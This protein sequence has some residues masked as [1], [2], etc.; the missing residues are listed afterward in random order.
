MAG[1]S[2]PTALLPELV[3]GPGPCAKLGVAIAVTAMVAAIT[4]MLGTIFMS[5]LQFREG[6]TT[7]SCRRSLRCADARDAE[8]RS[9]RLRNRAVP[10]LCKILRDVSL[11]GFRTDR[12]RPGT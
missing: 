2:A 4:P 6:S 5:V 1:P 12:V 11:V 9:L 3:Q 8:H 7:R 10:A